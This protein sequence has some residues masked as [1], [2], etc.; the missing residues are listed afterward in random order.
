[1][2]VKTI[3]LRAQKLKSR[4]ILY[5]PNS[6]VGGGIILLKSMIK[7]WPDGVPLEG[8]FDCR[9]RDFLDFKHDS[10]ITWVKPTITSRLKA[11]ISLS[12]TV[13]SN[14]VILFMNSL[15]PL[16][17]SRGRTIVF[18]Q[19]R[20]LVDS[21]SLCDFKLK[22]SIRIVIERI[23]SY[24]LR[25]R[26]DEYIVQTDSFKRNLEKW[27]KRSDLTRN[28]MVTVLPF[29]ESGE[30]SCSF[31]L[32]KSR[33]QHDFI[34]VADGLAHKNH[35][36]LFDA[37]E[38]LADKNC[39]PSL[40]ITLPVSEIGLL[41]RVSLL[42]EQG[43]KIVNLGW[44]SHSAVLLKY[45]SS[46][47]LIFPS[48]RESFGLPL[49]EASK[50]KIPILA[51][52]MDYVY[53]VCEPEETFDPTSPHSISRAVGRFLGVSPALRKVEAP[54]DF[55]SYIFRSKLKSGNFGEK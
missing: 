20:N 41:K 36:V 25:S 45:K 37:W 17:I 22:Q 49:V 54:E 28:P 11:E 33:T 8:Y 48:L 16:F 35:L 31:A 24:T 51:S 38:I 2:L 18:F 55:I 10:N 42:Q 14:D 15:P 23:L 43:L 44:L 40:A 46:G 5:A 9:A 7:N 3:H 47:A 26:V 53:D 12:R 29:M 32:D 4:V 21:I 34:Y 50:L 27:Y 19:N 39:F 6:H 30:F 52:E 1:V 13:S